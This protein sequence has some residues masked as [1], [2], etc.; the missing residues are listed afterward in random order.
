MLSSLSQNGLGEGG[1]LPPSSSCSFVLGWP[2]SL[3][4]TTCCCFWLFLPLFLDASY[5]FWKKF[6]EKNGVELSHTLQWKGV[7]VLNNIIISYSGEFIMCTITCGELKGEK[8]EIV[9][10]NKYFVKMWKNKIS[11]YNMSITCAW[12]IMSILIL[13]MQNK[14]KGK[15]GWNS[16]Y[17]KNWGPNTLEFFFF[18]WG[19]GFYFFE[20][21]PIYDQTQSCIVVF[22]TL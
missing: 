7:Q 10:C 18:F 12:M 20:S 16:V 2:W 11:N 21:H 14:E 17:H 1:S 8:N 19:V 13:V 3:L 22:L 6:G 15:T 9:V 5:S 4:S